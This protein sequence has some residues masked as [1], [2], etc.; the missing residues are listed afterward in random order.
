MAMFKLDSFLDTERDVLFPSFEEAKQAIEN[1]KEIK[2][3]GK[4]YG[5][6]CDRDD[7]EDEIV[8]IMKLY[9]DGERW[10]ALDVY[11]NTYLFVYD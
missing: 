8:R 7:G 10:K 4:V 1:G 2:I 9:K 6:C 11:G 5:S 3:R